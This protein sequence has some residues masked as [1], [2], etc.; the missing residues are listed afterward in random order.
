VITDEKIFFFLVDQNTLMPK[1]ENV[2]RNF[3]NCSM[4][5]I[6]KFVRFSITYKTNQPGFT[7]YKR[8]MYHNFKVAIDSN[9]YEGSFGINI[10]KLKRY[11]IGM[12]MTL[13]I[14]D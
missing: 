3:M 4:M 11:A 12:K 1:L 14:F 2:M 5:M 7:I 9:N 13:K 10:P 8:S 6:G